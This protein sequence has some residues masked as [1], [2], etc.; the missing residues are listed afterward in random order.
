MY[1]CK[2]GIHEAGEGTQ[3]PGQSGLQDS[4]FK[5]IWIYFIVVK[6]VGLPAYMS[7]HSLHA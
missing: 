7:V 4:G 5:K 1:T 2:H 3:V 6:C